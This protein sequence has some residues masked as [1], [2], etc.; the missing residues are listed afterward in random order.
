MIEITTQMGTDFNHPFKDL[1]MKA[2]K[3]CLDAK[4]ISTEG[5]GG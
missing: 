4:A 3:Q 5:E 2:I 1:D